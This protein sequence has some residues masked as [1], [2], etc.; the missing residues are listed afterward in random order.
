MYFFHMT[1]TLPDAANVELQETVVFALRRT[2]VVDDD[3]KHAL[4]DACGTELFTI[5]MDFKTYHCSSSGAFDRMTFHMIQ[6]S[7][8][9][10]KYRR[11]EKDSRQARFAHIR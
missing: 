9:R 2:Q 8:T 4:T 1:L 11:V 10:G 3:R 5:S 7:V 6:V